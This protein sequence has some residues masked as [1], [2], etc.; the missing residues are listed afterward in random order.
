M[1]VSFNIFQDEEPLHLPSVSNRQRLSTEGEETVEFQTI[2]T[3]PNAPV[4]GSLP[5]MSHEIP[6]GGGD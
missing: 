4:A 6:T 2:L 1:T 3:A 5:W